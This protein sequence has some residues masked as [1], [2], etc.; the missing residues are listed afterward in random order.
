MMENITALD[1]MLQIINI[2]MVFNP[3]R[4][5]LPLGGA[6]IVFGIL[7]AIPFLFRGSGLSSVSMMAMMAGL[8]LIMMGLLAE[9]L[10]QIRKKDL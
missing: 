4:I 10:A 9:Q 2:V 1:T 7:W 6:M 5:F 8:L 3:M